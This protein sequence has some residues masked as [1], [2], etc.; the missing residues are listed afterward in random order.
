MAITRLP[1]PTTYITERQSGEMQT[2]RSVGIA[3]RTLYTDYHR[4]HSSYTLAICVMPMVIIAVI[5]FIQQLKETQNN[6]R[7]HC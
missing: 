5:V 7:A 4:I 3:E 6:A 2:G 1:R